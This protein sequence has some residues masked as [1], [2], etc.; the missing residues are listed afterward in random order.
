MNVTEQFLSISVS[1]IMHV[2]QVSSM[3]KKNIICNKDIPNNIKN[4]L[5]LYHRAALS[6]NITKTRLF[7]YI[8]NFTSKKKT[9]NFQIKNSIFHISLKT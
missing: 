3:R 1:P 9:E 7:K 2:K 8:E 6:E 4:I 5:L